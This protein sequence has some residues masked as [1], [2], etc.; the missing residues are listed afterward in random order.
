MMASKSSWLIPLILVLGVAAALL[1]L[2]KYP[3]E[4]Q[5]VTEPLT[6]APVPPEE[7]SPRYPLPP[8]PEPQTESPP[9]PPL[10]LLEDSDDLVVQ[11]LN[12][13]VGTDIEEL[14]VNAL[15]IE[16]FVTTIDNLPRSHV[17]EKVRPLKRVS[18]LFLVESQEDGKIY[19]ISA[20][21]YRR[22]DVLVNLATSISAD[23]IAAT[24]RRLYPLLQEAYV[25]L[26]YPDGYFNDRTVEVIDHLL[27]T[28]LPQDPIL[29]VR[30]HVLYEYADPEIEELS[31]GQKLLL[32]MGSTNAARVRQ[33][34]RELRAQLAD[35]D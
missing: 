20:D 15:L 24:Y 19:S 34:L 17:A 11:T 1:Y 4:R 33:Q 21:N 25:N 14:L 9:L 28:P 31:S 8:P 2:S 13:L 23:R 6:P 35:N 12:E 30:P 3:Q 22:Y 26:G 27:E 16:K 10:P 32:R 7:E 29:L 18:G 5:T